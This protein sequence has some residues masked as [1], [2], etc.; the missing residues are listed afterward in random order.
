MRLFIAEGAFMSILRSWGFET[1]EE[2]A[3]MQR[4]PKGPHQRSMAPLHE[5]DWCKWN[6]RE[7]LLQHNRDLR[8]VVQFYRR[9]R[10]NRVE[11]I[12]KQV[13]R[14][15]NLSSRGGWFVRPEGPYQP[16]ALI[17]LGSMRVDHAAGAVVAK[18]CRLRPDGDRVSEIFVF[19]HVMSG[20]ER[21]APV[22]TV[23]GLTLSEHRQFQ[24]NCRWHGRQAGSLSRAYSLKGRKYETRGKSK[25]TLGAK[26]PDR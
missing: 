20:K 11:L 10:R 21:T 13:K 19:P 7:N 5:R 16:E 15:I 12:A 8:K 22:M 1:I 26:G 24:A 6:A 14:I 25:R 9:Q 4:P 3:F 2:F 18:G 17:R 23:G